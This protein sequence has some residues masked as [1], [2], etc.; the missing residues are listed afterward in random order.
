MRSKLSPN[1]L[2]LRMTLGL[3]KDSSDTLDIALLGKIPKRL[4]QKLLS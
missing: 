2:E 3:L 4:S 1:K